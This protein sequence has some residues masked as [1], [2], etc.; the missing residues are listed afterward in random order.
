[1]NILNCFDENLSEDLLSENAAKPMVRTSLRL[2]KNMSDSPFN[3]KRE[4]DKSL[5]MAS[6]PLRSMT[7]EPMAFLN[8]PEENSGEPQSVKLIP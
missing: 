8:L 4:L 7:K 5:K 3:R 2:E 1:M 6:L